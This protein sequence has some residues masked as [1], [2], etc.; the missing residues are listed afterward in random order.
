MKINVLKNQAFLAFSILFSISLP[1]FAQNK[2]KTIEQKIS[3]LMQKMTLEE[4]VGQMNQYNGFWEVTG[5][6]PGEGNAR[7]K[8]EH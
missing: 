6:A 4:K 1:A 5:P 7:L 3:E 8:Y 2:P